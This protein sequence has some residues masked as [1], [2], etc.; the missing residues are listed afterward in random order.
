MRW[1]RSGRR[2]CLRCEPLPDFVH[3]ADDLIQFALGIFDARNFERAC[4]LPVVRLVFTKEDRDCEDER[5]GD[6]GDHLAVGEI[7]PHLLLEPRT[8]PATADFS[9][10][11]NRFAQTSRRLNAE[12][13]EGKGSIG[14]LLFVGP[15]GKGRVGL[16]AGD[17]FG[18]CGVGIVVTAGPAGA[19]EEFG[20]VAHCAAPFV[21]NC[22]TFSA[23]VVRLS[24]RS[25]RSCSLPRERRDITVPMGVSSNSAISL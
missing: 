23:V 17:C 19:Q 2:A 5:D 6:G 8:Q 7:S 22:T 16:G 25:L 20:F 3:V 24:R 18:D 9:A 4:A 10:S 15:R 12:K 11:Q 14:A 1:Q 21:G 13:F